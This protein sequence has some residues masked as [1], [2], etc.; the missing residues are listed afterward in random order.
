VK[1]E[2]EGVVPSPV[3]GDGLIFTASGFSKPTIRAVRSGGE[4]GVTATHLVWEQTQGVPMIP[5]FVYLRPHLYAVTTNGFAFC[6]EARD[7]KVV[8]QE[9]IGG[10]FSASPVY[11]DGCLYLLAEDGTTTVLEAGPTFKR[12]ARNPLNEAAQASMAVSGGQFFIRTEHHLWCIGKAKETPNGKS[13]EPTASTLSP[14]PS[15]G[16]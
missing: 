16:R 3:I 15:S 10:A 2:G 1:S 13:G 9:R 8:W 11:A 5:S 12:I 4:G 6:F 14:P 7:G